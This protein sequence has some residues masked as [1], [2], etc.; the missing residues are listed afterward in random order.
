ML[1]S[2]PKRNGG[3]NRR[4]IA[5]LLVLIA[6]VMVMVISATFVVSQGTALGIS[7]NI[8]RNARA[9]SIAEAAV[10]MTVRS[11]LVDTNWRT[12]R[13]NGAWAT[14]SSYDGGTVSVSVTDDTDGNLKDDPTQPV[15]I[16][17]TATF[18]GV[19][20][21][22]RSVV[23]PNIPV[24]RKL[25]MVV[26][27]SASLT[28][29]DSV[30]KGMFEGW[31]YQ[32]TL[33]SDNSSAAAYTAAIV[34]QNVVFI[35][36]ECTGSNVGNKLLAS[37][38]GVVIEDAA[39][40]NSFLMSSAAGTTVTS[41]RIT[42]VDNSHYITQPFSTGSLII[43]STTTA[44][45]R[46]NGTLATGDSTLANSSAGNNP[47][48]VVID[49]NGSQT[50][51]TP[52]YGRRVLLPWGGDAFDVNL[53][54][55][56]GKNVLKRSL[57]WA[58]QPVVPRS[59]IAHWTMG[60]L[61]GAICYDAIGTNHGTYQNGVW[62]GQK[63]PM[64]N[65]ASFDG[66]NDFVIVPNAAVLNLTS[67]IT[68]TAWIYPNDWSNG[69]HRI[70][71]K[72]NSDNQYRLTGESGV[73]KWQ[74]TGVS[75]ITAAFPATGAWVHVAATYN[76]TRMCIY[77]NGLLVS[78]SNVTGTVA[79]TS[80]PFQIGTKKV[81]A[82]PSDSFNGIIDDVQVFDYGLNAA[83][84]YYLFSQG[85]LD[86]N[87]PLPQ[88]T[89][90]YDFKQTID[91][92][93]LIH[94]WKLDETGGGGGAA[95][96]QAVNINS[97]SVTIGYDSTNGPFG[98]GN[99]SASAVVSSNLTS[100]GA[101]AVAS[102]ASLNGDAYCGTG[103]TVGTAITGSSCITGTRAAMSA[104]VVFPAITLPSGMPATLGNVTY[105]S[106][107]AIN[108]NRRFNN[109]TISGSAQVTITGTVNIQCDGNFSIANT[110]AI[111][112]P[113]GSR[114]NLYVTGAIDVNDTAQ[115]NGDTSGPGRLWIYHNSASTSNNV[116]L[117]NQSMMSAVIQTLQ[118][119]T[120]NDQ[121]RFY[122][123]VLA[124]KTITTNG[125]SQ[126]QLD[127]AQASLGPASAPVGDAAGGFVGSYRGATLGNAGFGD[128]GTSAGFNG[129][130]QY[131]LVNHSNT[132]LLNQGSVSFWFRSTNLTGNHGLIA[133]TST[134]YATGGH[135]YIYTSGN[136]LR[137]TLASTTAT[138]TLSPGNT[139]AANTWY[140]VVF[141][142]GPGGMQLYLNGAS[143]ATN[144]YIGGLGSSSGGTGNLEPLIIGAGTT[145]AT[146][147]T[148]A[149]M[150]EYF[151]G[152]IDDVRIYNRPLETAQVLNV[153]NRQ[154][155]TASAG[156]SKIVNDTAGSGEPLD[157][158]IASP[159]A[160]SWVN[161]GG[162]D[163]ISATRISSPV[164]AAKLRSLLTQTNQFSIQATFLPAN[165]TQTSSQVFSY[166]NSASLT[167]FSLG[168]GAQTYITA[169]RTSTT[170]NA[171]A[172]LQTSGN[173]LSAT[174]VQNVILTYDG[175]N[176]KA[177]RNGALE[178]TTAK[179]G[180]FA[181]WDAAY[182]FI[183]AN[184]D[185]DSRP[186]LGRLQRVAIYNR[187]FNAIQVANVFA[188][189]PPGDG[190]G[191]QHLAVQWDELP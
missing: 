156:P 186:W 44:M 175:T 132:M 115:L 85:S 83:E 173:V 72:G 14:N 77:Y 190:T 45:L 157:L 81:G 78:S 106:N 164:A 13:T 129:S 99:M 154:T 127:V 176:L 91:N 47:S 97:L 150:N 53:L 24:I 61:T 56:D 22:V 149:P 142:F 10:N 19:T 162:L 3:R 96:G 70:L 135:F 191:V 80:D 143:V 123:R 172:P 23:V 58:A 15:T 179:T 1:R 177:Y 30:K 79:T 116:N 107:T 178:Q 7:Q 187:A 105:S 62:L 103:G 128:G 136:Q 33:L 34:A 153:Y 92:P 98:A 160:V 52:S 145:T 148:Y 38:I 140:H 86:A 49:A 32:V 167:N 131:V 2:R 12:T 125:D 141:T 138:N 134:G 63:G 60:E 73:L 181:N 111:I 4:G 121:S 152:Q 50:N 169:L 28:A 25:L 158:Y 18:Q 55:K 36:E 54:N 89:A 59:P 41:D 11:M 46:R 90:L 112:I 170:S 95:A 75:T 29:Q 161:G 113:V 168:Q 65:A 64:G 108:A 188:A 42:V 110:A 20:H 119:F 124:T 66:Q 159:A 185:T 76:G 69:N 31:G 6:I 94:N 51:S 155:L 17:A 74:L 165:I 146:T 68:I 93:T 16:L 43:T 82:P 37:P 26:P 88:L 166:A 5:M 57:D 182:K 144:A 147:L 189:Q 39:I 84:V 102:Q 183:L 67:Q 117:R 35:S 40:D 174:T 118:A 48:L 171:G 27:N 71:Q 163:V 151:A 101:V 100:A 21:R 109:L 8:D 180:T 104:N 139:L 137:C 120:T 130:S 87:N 133:K 122:G 9:R 126:M 114:L 184:S